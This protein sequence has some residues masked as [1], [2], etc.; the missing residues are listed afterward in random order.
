LNILLKDLVMKNRI[1]HPLWT[2]LPAA[3][4]L[5]VLVVYIIAAGPFEGRVPIHFSFGGEPNDYGSPWSV[6]GL[7]IGLSVFFILLSAFL[8]ELWARQENAK[9]FNWL[10]LLDDVVVGTMAGI[11][12][13]Y[14]FY[15]Q[16]GSNAYEFPWNYLGIVG[17]GA[18]VLAILLEIVRPCRPS[19]GRLIVVKNETLKSELAARLK[20]DSAFAYWDYQNPLYVTVL[21]TLLPLVLLLGAALSWLSQ[22]WVAILL[23][24]VAILLTIPYGGLRTVVTRQYISVR[25]GLLGIRVLKIKT[26]EITGVELHQFRPLK[27][28]GGYGIRFNREMNAYF[29]R[30]TTGVKITGTGGKPNLIGSDTPEKLAAV[31]DAVISNR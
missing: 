18:I 24:I 22:V 15:L 31:I 2:H 21:T 13:G 9:T 3:A 20:G 12:L 19:P 16:N 6:F 27:D 17:G 14:L 30:G 5:I 4:A 28:F 8:D 29:L 11:T 1:I 26:G 25:F 23:I 10:S 7:I